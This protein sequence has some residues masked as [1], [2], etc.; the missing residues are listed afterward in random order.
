[1]GCGGL[2]AALKAPKPPA[3][4]K[5]IGWV[6]GTGQ[7]RIESTDV[8][9]NNYEAVIPTF[10]RRRRSLQLALKEK[11]LLRKVVLSQQALR[12]RQEILMKH[13]RAEKERIIEVRTQFILPTCEFIASSNRSVLVLSAK[14]ACCRKKFYFCSTLDFGKR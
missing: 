14:W 10:L 2:A 11:K 13:L 1:M 5:C 7:V 8:A 4:R 9:S 12:R 6:V 3:L